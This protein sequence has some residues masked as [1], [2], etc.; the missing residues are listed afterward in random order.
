MKLLIR[1]I[2][3]MVLGHLSL[4]A[5]AQDECSGLL[6]K[7]MNGFVEL[8][9]SSGSDQLLFMDYSMAVDYADEEIPDQNARIKMLAGKGGLHVDSPDLQ[10][11]ADKSDYFMVIPS[12]KKIIR[13]LSSPNLID[14]A[15]YNQMIVNQQEFFKHGT[16]TICRATGSENSGYTKFLEFVP[17]AE[18]VEN[19]YITRVQLWIH[20]GDMRLAKMK[21]FYLEGHEVK[22]MQMEF[23]ALEP[24]YTKKKLDKTAASRFIGPDGKLK[25]EFKGYTL[26]VNGE[27]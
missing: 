3:F 10:F 16:F 4:P 24:N 26:T 15:V 27:E 2:V 1:I 8:K 19:I 18:S 25:P 22:T 12:R 20:E 23:H 14:S 21:T 9:K 17:V 13:G 5:L 6:T 7:V 11:F